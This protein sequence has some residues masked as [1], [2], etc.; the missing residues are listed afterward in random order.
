MRLDK[1]MWGIVLLFIGGVLL[2]ENFEVID[3]YWRNVWRFWPIFLIIAGVNI[4]FN[5]NKS[6]VGSIISIVILLAT[7][8][9]LFVKGQENPGK[10]GAINLG[11]NAKEDSG[12]I[13]ELHF[14][15]PFIDSAGRKTELHISGGGTTFSLNG[16][17]DSLIAADVRKTGGTFALKNE[18]NDGL[19]SLDF[20]MKGNANWT[21]GE[22]GNAVA[23]RLNA[24]PNWDISVNLG[25]GSID[26]DLSDYKVSNFNFDGGAASVALKLGELVPLAN[27][28]VKTGM[29]DVKIEVPQSVGCRI[30]AKTGLSAKEFNGFNKIGDGIYESD[31]YEKTVKKILI[32]LDGGLSNFEVNRY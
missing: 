16:N 29:A 1:V 21:V 9:L 24:K 11:M 32:N 25:A 2:L 31:N 14:A 19:R 13:E 26:F 3:F 22:G 23:L 17:T 30:K 27:V 8:T 10:R 12:K 18:D 5:R 20:K 6:Q 15:E 4:L 28:K 7:L